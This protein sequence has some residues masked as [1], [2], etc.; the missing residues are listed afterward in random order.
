MQITPGKGLENTENAFK[1]CKTPG[2]LTLDQHDFLYVFVTKSHVY[3]MRTHKLSPE[4]IEQVF[5]GEFLSWESTIRTSLKS[6]S[7]LGLLEHILHISILQGTQ[8]CTT[9]KNIRQQN[10]IPLPDSRL[11]KI[12]ILTKVL[13][14]FAIYLNYSNYI[15]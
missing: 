7:E 13:S 6:L 11:V 10:I 8:V 15:F 3:R 1:S 2:L 14:D 4:I 5:D 9:L 12:Q